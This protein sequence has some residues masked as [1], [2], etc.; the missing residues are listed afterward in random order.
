MP[1]SK[2]QRKSRCLQLLLKMSP[3]SGLR[4]LWCINTLWGEGSSPG[5]LGLNLGSKPSCRH[6]AISG[7]EK[8]YYSFGSDGN[9]LATD[10]I[11]MVCEKRNV[12]RE[13]KA[14]IPYFYSVYISTSQEARAF[15][16]STEKSREFSFLT[17]CQ[18]GTQLKKKKIRSKNIRPWHPGL[19]ERE[20]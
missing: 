4:P 12:S 1:L 17:V 18:S 15:Y 7:D 20:P 9:L 3:S 10:L 14:S 13:M 11:L 2:R 5:T 16:R 6:L 8:F 19:W